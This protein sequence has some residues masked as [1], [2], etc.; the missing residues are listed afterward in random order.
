MKSAFNQLRQKILAQPGARP[1]IFLVGPVAFNVTQQ[2]SD[3]YWSLRTLVHS[4]KPCQR[5][6]ALVTFQTRRWALQVVLLV[7][8]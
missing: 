3:I 8:S 7:G 5:A 6:P 4:D 2:G 1:S